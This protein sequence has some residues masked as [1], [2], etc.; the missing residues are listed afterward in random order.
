MLFAAGATLF[1]H[2][3]LGVDPLDVLS[4]ALLE[5]LP[6]TI[7]IAQADERKP[8]RGPEPATGPSARSSGCLPVDRRSSD[9]SHGADQAGRSSGSVKPE[10][11]S[12]KR[13]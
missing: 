5:H 12:C 6:L 13:V 1:I 7:G 11:S 2:A 9:P 3:G 10:T 4:L 8:F